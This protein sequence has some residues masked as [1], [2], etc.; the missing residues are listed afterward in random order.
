MKASAGGGSGGARGD[1]SPTASWCKNCGGRRKVTYLGSYVPYVSDICCSGTRALGGPG[2]PKATV[3]ALHWTLAL[4]QLWPPH[5]HTRRHVRRARRGPLPV[6]SDTDL[7]GLW[8]TF[9]Q[10]KIGFHLWKTCFFWRLRLR[11]RL[12]KKPAPQN[13][14]PPLM[15]AKKSCF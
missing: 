3:P 1:W 5:A 8:D 14:N 11:N 13:T 7:G 10:K 6:S 12:G 9:L 15:N 2:P 4:Y